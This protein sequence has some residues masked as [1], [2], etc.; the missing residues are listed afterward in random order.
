MARKNGIS[1]RQFQYFIRLKN[2]LFAASA[3]APRTAIKKKKKLTQDKKKHVVLFAGGASP[4]RAVSKLTSRSMYAAL[5][6]RGYAVT[7]L[8]PA[9]GKEQP[10]SVDAYFEHGDCAR[11]SAANYLECVA[12]CLPADTDVVLLGLHG[13]YGEDGMVQSLLEL[14]GVPYTGSGV[15]ASSLAMDKTMA[16]I[17]MK[18][19]GVSVPGGFPVSK[20]KF[21]EEEV[22]EKTKLTVGFPCVVKPNDEGSTYG[23]T[24]CTNVD[25]LPAA[26]AESFRFSPFMMIEEYIPGRELTAGIVGDAVLPVLEI[27]PKHTLYDYECKYTSGMS[28]YLVPAPIGEETALLVQRESLLA[29]ASLGC[30]SYGR[31]DFRLTPEGKVYCLEMNTLPGMTSTSLIPKMARHIGISFPDL[32]EKIIEMALE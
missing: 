16:K 11:V 13:K 4:E 30:A 8:D 12:H 5:L 25:D 7:V 1:L 24:I 10:G 22:I 27:R 21:S 17:I 2:H 14:S 23:L 19:H 32:I 31:A 18:D 9:Y 26:F 15:L 29:F 20:K 3:G 28:E 6:E